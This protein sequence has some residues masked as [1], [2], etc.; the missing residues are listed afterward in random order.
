MSNLRWKLGNGRGGLYIRTMEDIPLIGSSPY[1]NYYI[2]AENVWKA[3]NNHV[4]KK[5]IFGEEDIQD[6]VKQEERYYINDGKRNRSLT[7]AMQ[8]FHNEVKRI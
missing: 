4:T 8:L 5:I 1:G 7:L 2:V 3:I 6:T